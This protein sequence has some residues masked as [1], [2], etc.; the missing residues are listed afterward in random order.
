MAPHNTV[1]DVFSAKARYGFSG[2][3]ITQSG[4]MN[5]KLIGLVTQRDID[6]LSADEQEVTRVEEVRAASQPTAGHLLAHACS[7][8]VLA[9]Y[10]CTSRVVKPLRP[11]IVFKNTN[12]ALIQIHASVLKI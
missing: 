8:I 5:G 7:L 12:Y 6:F 1:K 3:P 9:Q 11:K 4:K 2:I 10:A